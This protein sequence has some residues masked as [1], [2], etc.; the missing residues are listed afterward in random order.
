MGEGLD[1]YWGAT[2]RFVL[3]RACEVL[4]FWNGRLE[5]AID[6]GHAKCQIAYK[7]LLFTQYIPQQILERSLE[8]KKP[9]VS[10]RPWDSFLRIS[11]C[12]E[13]DLPILL[14][15]AVALSTRKP[16]LLRT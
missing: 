8:K 5:R 7:L 12:L 2:I 16:L 1:A 11:S 6:S 15:S 9:T 10:S 13:T 3:W 4:E 14:G